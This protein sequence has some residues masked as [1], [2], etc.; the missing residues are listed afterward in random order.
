[1]RGVFRADRKFLA[2]FPSLNARRFSVRTQMPGNYY[3]FDRDAV[4]EQDRNA[5]RYLPIWMRGECRSE[6]KFLA[7]FSSV[8]A[9]RFSVR[10]QIPGNSYH[11]ACELFAGQNRNSWRYFPI[12]MRVVCR[13]E[14]EFLAVCS[15]SRARCP[16]VRTIIPG[17]ISQFTYGAF[18]GQ[19]RNSWRYVPICMRGACRSEL[20]LLGTFP[21]L[22]ARGFSVR[23]KVPGGVFQFKCDAFYGQNENPWQ[24]FPV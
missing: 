12:L 5:W 10:T 18:F 6:P 15:C 22:N 7:M 16:S 21:S 24:Y 3:Q 20:K 13:S 23:A 8:N 17:D 4:F 2:V 9:R 19:R 1:M 14:P 11:F